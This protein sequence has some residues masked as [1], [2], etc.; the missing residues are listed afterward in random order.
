MHPK[1]DS[2]GILKVFLRILNRDKTELLV[3]NMLIKMSSEKCPEHIYAHENINSF[4]LWR[5][6]RLYQKTSKMTKIKSLEH[7]HVE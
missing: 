2:F 3:M 6:L 1:N 4:S 7:L 5:A